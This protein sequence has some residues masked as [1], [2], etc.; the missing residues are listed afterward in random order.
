LAV[1]R[2]AWAGGVLE[3]AGPHYSFPRVLATEEPVRV[4]LILGGNTDRALRRAARV[5]DGW[6]SSGNPT[7]EEACRLRARLR[8]LGDELGR[9]RPLPIYVRIAGR[10]PAAVARYAEH[11]FEHVTVW[12]NQ[13]WP[14][15]GDLASKRERFLEGSR[16]LVPLTLD[17]NS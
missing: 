3:G 9:E 11:G 4:P 13:L 15:D 7:F 12:A 2:A 8:E 5:A 14:D 10:D 1:L 16:T 17:G 6:F